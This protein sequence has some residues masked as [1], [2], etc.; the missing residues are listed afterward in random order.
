M[1]TLALERE[2]SSAD[3]ARLFAM[4]NLAMAD[5]QVSES[6]GRFRT[7][8]RVRR[9]CHP[10]GAAGATDPARPAGRNLRDPRTAKASGRVRPKPSDSVGARVSF[11]DARDGRPFHVL[12]GSKDLARRGE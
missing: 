7:S 4:G 8:R 5:A 3:S 10:N 11:T 2:L 9:S 12:S 1:N 6:L